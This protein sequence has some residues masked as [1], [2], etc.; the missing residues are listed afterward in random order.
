MKFHLKGNIRVL[1]IIKKNTRTQLIIKAK[2]TSRSDSTNGK[3]LGL[4]EITIVKKL[5]FSFIVNSC[6]RK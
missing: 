6:L 2:R 1:E 3:F 5:N 4:P